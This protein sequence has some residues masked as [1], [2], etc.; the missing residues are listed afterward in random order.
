MLI[1]WMVN[2]TCVVSHASYTEDLRTEGRKINVVR[3]LRS[4]HFQSLLECTPVFIRRTNEMNTEHATEAG[5][6]RTS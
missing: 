6:A 4:C 1:S 5:S 3:Y 2:I